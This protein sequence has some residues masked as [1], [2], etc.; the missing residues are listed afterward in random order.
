MSRLHH[1]KS[2]QSI[3]LLH[4]LCI[5]LYRKADFSK[6][7]MSAGIEA[8][9]LLIRFM[10]GTMTF[11]RLVVHTHVHCAGSSSSCLSLKD[12]LVIRHSDATLP[13]MVHFDAFH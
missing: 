3:A 4:R 13:A 2:S 10:A 11:Q 5:V 1:A 6:S 9:E 8:M 12:E 7:Y